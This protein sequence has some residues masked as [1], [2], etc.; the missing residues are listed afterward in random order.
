MTPAPSFS[1]APISSSAS[2]SLTASHTRTSTLHC[3]LTPITKIYFASA[4]LMFTVSLHAGGSA[5]VTSPV[6]FS[7]LAPTTLILSLLSTSGYTLIR[8]V[9]KLHSKRLG[10]QNSPPAALSR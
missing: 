4:S 3:L 1:S 9:T 10:P 6:H 7:A 2:M 5:P 8:L